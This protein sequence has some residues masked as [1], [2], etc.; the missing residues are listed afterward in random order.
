MFKISAGDGLPSPCM[1]RFDEVFSID[2]IFCM[3]A[4]LTVYL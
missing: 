3:L 2:L 1:E 4:Q